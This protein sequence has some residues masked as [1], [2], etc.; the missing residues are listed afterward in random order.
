MGGQGGVA[1]GYISAANGYA[2]EITSKISIATGYGAE[3]QSKIAIGNGYIAEA[4][5]RL[6]MDSAK[7]QWY[8]DQYTKLTAEYTRGLAA[9]KGT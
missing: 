1:T 3:V 4:T 5:A 7:Y 6:S 2:Q 9:L 8:G